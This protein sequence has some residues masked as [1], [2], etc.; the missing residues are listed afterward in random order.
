MDIDL[1]LT[2]SAY[3]I[4]VDTFLL[5]ERGYAYATYYPCTDGNQI[6]GFFVRTDS[7]WPDEPL[8]EDLKAC[9]EFATGNNCT[10][11]RLDI[12]AEEVVGL[13]TYKWEE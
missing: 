11:L 12:D 2:I 9:M 1:I 13:P 4:S 7:E 5:M 8:P 6:Y 10:W 3:H